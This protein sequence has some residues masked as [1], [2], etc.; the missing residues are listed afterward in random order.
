MTDYIDLVEKICSFAC[1]AYP[2]CKGCDTMGHECRSAIERQAADAIEELSHSVELL[3]DANKSL[4]DAVSEWIS[5]EERLPEETHSIFFPRY[6]T[7]K[8]SSAMW[9]EQS[10]NVIVTVAF[11]D[12]TR[13]ATIGKTHDG[14]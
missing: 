1:K 3:G 7:Q 14:V 12:G 2:N 10:D 8:W 9:K 6:G 11:K 5:V 13:L 4:M